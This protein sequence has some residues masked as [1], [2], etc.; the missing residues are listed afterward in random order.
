MYLIS[1]LSPLVR[2]RIKK[3]E[4]T[5]F[6]VPIKGNSSIPL[7]IASSQKVFRSIC[8]SVMEGHLE[9]SRRLPYPMMKTSWRNFLCSKTYSSK[10]IIKDMKS[11][12]SVDQDLQ[13]ST[14][15]CIGIWRI[16]LVYESRHRHF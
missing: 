2:F 9:I 7:C 16:I 11:P 1:I 15:W 6:G 5:N 4:P 14:I 10:M 12:I 13:V 3:M 8:L